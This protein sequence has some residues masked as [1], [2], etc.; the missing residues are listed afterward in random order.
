MMQTIPEN[1]EINIRQMFVS[2][3]KQISFKHLLRLSR[4]QDVDREFQ[5]GSFSVC[6]SAGL[7]NVLIDTN[8]AYW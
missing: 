3:K 1:N 2:A 6:T 4:Q 8:S 5:T 7:H